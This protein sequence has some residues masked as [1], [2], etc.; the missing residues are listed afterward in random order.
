MAMAGLLKASR[1]AGVAMIL[2]V[3]GTA[4]KGTVPKS[5]LCSAAAGRE[6]VLASD[7]AG[8]IRSEEGDDGC[9]VRWLADAAKR[10]VR[11][12]SLLE[13]GADNT[14]TMRALRLDHAR[15]H[16]VDAD[17]SGTELFREHAGDGIDRTFGRAID[18]VTGWRERGSPASRY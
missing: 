15:V 16:S 12:G 18:C 6:Q 8:I 14:R 11:H 13:I 10:R 2:E 9:D 5:R 17:F 7:P 4:P 3:T 1:L